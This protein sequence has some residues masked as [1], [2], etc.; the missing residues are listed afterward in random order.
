MSETQYWY[1]TATREVEEGH[2]SSW[3][4]LMGPYAT[5]AEAEQAL[6]RAAARNQAW[7]DQ[8]ARDRR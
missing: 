6:S 5:R 8:D 7:D 3:T 1:N 4:N 2:K